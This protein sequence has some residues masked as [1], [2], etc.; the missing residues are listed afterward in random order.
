MEIIKSRIQLARNENQLYK[1]HT[2]T[3][4]DSFHS[5]HEVNHANY[6]K[7]IITDDQN[8]FTWNKFDVLFIFFHFSSIF[9]YCFKLIIS[10]LPNSRV[11][12]CNFF[13]CNFPL[14]HKYNICTIEFTWMNNEWLQ[15]VQIYVKLL[16]LNSI[17]NTTHEVKCWNSNK[18]RERTETITD[19][20]GNA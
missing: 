15:I 4:D 16:N 3:T 19:I 17:R 5:N 1:H 10:I 13:F 14:D 8:K 6:P 18:V 7:P 12:C 20:V 9:F 11:F 2:L